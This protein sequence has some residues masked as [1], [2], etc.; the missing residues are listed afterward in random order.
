M[1]YWKG[2]PC[3]KSM[4]DVFYMYVRQSMNSFIFASQSQLSQV[5]TLKPQE[6]LWAANDLPLHTSFLA[7]K[8]SGLL[9]HFL[10]HDFIRF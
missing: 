2:E 5:A 1:Q 8:R 4:H 3:R 10:V 9:K 6:I 7:Y